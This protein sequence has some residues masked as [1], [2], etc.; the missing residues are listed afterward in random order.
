MNKIMCQVN[1][2]HLTLRPQIRENYCL[3]ITYQIRSLGNKRLVQNY[4]KSLLVDPCLLFVNFEN[5]I[6]QGSK[7]IYLKFLHCSNSR[8]LFENKYHFR[9]HFNYSG[10]IF[11]N[12]SFYI[13]VFWLPPKQSNLPWNNINI[14]TGDKT[15]T[16]IVILRYNFSYLPRIFGYLQAF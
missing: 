14:L 1:Y 5:Y 6:E 11:L 16:I 8:L 7:P 15:L 4:S 3:L 2:S 9:E 12:Y 10:R 13:M